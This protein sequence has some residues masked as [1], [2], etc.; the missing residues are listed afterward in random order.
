M[1]T[2]RF[3]SVLEIVEERRHPRI[4]LATPLICHFN[5]SNCNSSYCSVR[6]ISKGG[7]RVEC[8][9]NWLMD[10]LEPGMTVQLVECSPLER[11]LFTSVEGMLV[12]HSKNHYGISF[13]DE[14]FMPH[15][16]LDRWLS[17]NGFTA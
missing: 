5:L 10:E 14:L 1:D 9:P 17:K 3:E 2:R 8:R 13:Y 4:D 11:A 12:W 7:A 15:H 16:E 6:N